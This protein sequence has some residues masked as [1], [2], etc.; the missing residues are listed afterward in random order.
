[1]NRDPYPGYIKPESNTE[2]SAGI[3]VYKVEGYWR[4]TVTLAGLPRYRGERLGRGAL[5]TRAEAD[6]AARSLARH[7]LEKAANAPLEYTVKLE[8]L[9]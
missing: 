2:A 4:H 8:D 1:M 9:V 7:M 3:F 5:L 6:K